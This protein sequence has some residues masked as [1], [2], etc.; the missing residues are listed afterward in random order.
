VR[1]GRAVDD[2]GLAEAAVR[3]ARRRQQQL[4]RERWVVLAFLLMAAARVPDIVDAEGTRQLV[5]GLVGGLGFLAAAIT[6]PLAARRQSR[7]L[8]LALRTNENVGGAPAPAGEGGEPR[9]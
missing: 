7:R 2:P 8:G 6:W 1:A 5:L 9:A 4:R 3:Y